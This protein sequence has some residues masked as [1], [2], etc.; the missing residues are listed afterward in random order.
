MIKSANDQ[1][2]RGLQLALATPATNEGSSERGQSLSVGDQATFRWKEDLRQLRLGQNRLCEA[3]YSIDNDSTLAATGGGNKN[4]TKPSLFNTPWR[5]LTSYL[6]ED[7]HFGTSYDFNYTR[8]SREGKLIVAPT[9]FYAVV[10]VVVV[11]M[12]YAL[13]NGCL[14]SSQQAIFFK[15]Y[16]A[17]LYFY[18]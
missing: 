12:M 11:V 17:F 13:A 1:Q 8:Y 14:P 3:S 7:H 5:I 9:F 4:K 10:V 16:P 6:N 2:D 15:R 18:F